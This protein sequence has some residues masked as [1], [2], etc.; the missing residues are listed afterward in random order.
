MKNCFFISPIGS[1]GSEVRKRADDV[2]N[3]IVKPALEEIG[4][5]VERADESTEAG[6][7]SKSVIEKVL[8][9]DLVVADLSNHNPN[10]FYELALRHAIAKPFVQIIVK[11]EKIPF[12]IF[13]IRTISYE[14]DLAGADKAKKAIQDF[15]KTVQDSD[16]V[17]TPVTEVISLSN[18]NFNNN[19]ESDSSILIEELQRINQNI[20]NLEHKLAGRFEQMITQSSKQNLN[21]QDMSMEDR[22]G[23][24]FMEKLFEN[25]SKSDEMMDLINKLNTLNHKK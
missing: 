10:V 4:Y 1:E 13:D 24:A 17:E 16:R 3:Y 19:G 11:D 15:T 20:N 2:L 5:K 23:M 7:I 8:H 21:M 25:P 6:S 18:L 9:S 12:D 22:L 14:L